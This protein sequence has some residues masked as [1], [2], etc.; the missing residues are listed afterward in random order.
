MCL[1]VRLLKPAT[2]SFTPPFSCLCIYVLY[3][4]WE[5]VPLHLHLFCFC[6]S[7]KWKMSLLPRSRC[8]I[9]PQRVTL[10]W[11][12]FPIPPAHFFPSYLPFF[13]LSISLPIDCLH[14]S[15]HS[16]SLRVYYQGAAIENSMPKMYRAPAN[17]YNSPY[18]A[19]AHWQTFSSDITRGTLANWHNNPRTNAIALALFSP[20]FKYKKLLVREG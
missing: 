5:A 19:E 16:K 2:S 17:A 3:T 18:A 15:S 13:L 6:V 14:S 9:S 20:H 7:S 10:W 12:E 11:Q 1:T 4:S 8:Y